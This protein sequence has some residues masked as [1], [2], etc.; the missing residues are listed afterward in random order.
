MT[1]CEQLTL[2]SH[3]KSCKQNFLIENSSCVKEC[4]EGFF[5]KGKTCVGE[6][7]T[8]D[9]RLLCFVHEITG[10]SLLFAK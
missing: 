8:N 4:S 3:C 2:S 7:F 10:N 6:S 5:E 1:G 9:F